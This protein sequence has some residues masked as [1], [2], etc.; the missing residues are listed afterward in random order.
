MRL[1]WSSRRSPTDL[2]EP[3]P[4]LEPVLEFELCRPWPEKYFGQRF[5]PSYLRKVLASGRY[6]MCEIDTIPEHWPV[7][8]A[9]W[10]DGVLLVETLQGWKVPTRMW[11]V[12]SLKGIKL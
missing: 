12:A 2:D 10:A 8:D 9:K 4:K 3:P 5:G 7:S 11:T 1:N 6:I